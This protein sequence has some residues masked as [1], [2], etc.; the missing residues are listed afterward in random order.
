MVVW[1]IA[2]RYMTLAVGVVE[3]VVLIMHGFDGKGWPPM[4]GR[5]LDRLLSPPFREVLGVGFLRQHLMGK[6]IGVD[7]VGIADL[8]QAVGG[9][10][11]PLLLLDIEIRDGGVVGLFDAGIYACLF[12]PRRPFVVRDEGEMSCAEGVAHAAVAL[13]EGEAHEAATEVGDKALQPP[14]SFH[15]FA[16]C[17]ALPVGVRHVHDAFLI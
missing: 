10:R 4:H 5:Q 14:R 2:A 9:E 8:A 6:G 3:R 1:M 12:C 15:S 16:P 11:A 7:V 13:D 17:E